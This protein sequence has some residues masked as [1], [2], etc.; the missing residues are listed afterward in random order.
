MSR[1]SGITGQKNSGRREK[2]LYDSGERVRAKHHIKESAQEWETTFNS[3]EDLVSIHDRDFG[4]VKVNRAFADAFKMRPEEVIG[5]KCYEIVHGM[6]KPWPTCP[7]R[8]AMEN[9]RHAAVDFFEPRM[10]VHLEVSCSP[11]FNDRNEVTG[12]VHIAKNITEQRK[13]Y[14]ELKKRSW[15]LEK[16]KKELEGKIREFERLNELSIGRELKMVELKR[17]IEELEEELKGVRK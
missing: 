17:K 16:S 3:I 2:I 11:I 9:K 4:I 5:K 12:V 7:L 10:G 1:K 6:K 13:S 15:E 8:Q 14:E